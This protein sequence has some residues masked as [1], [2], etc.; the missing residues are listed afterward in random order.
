[1]LNCLSSKAVGDDDRQEREVSNGAEKS[2]LTGAFSSRLVRTWW[3]RGRRRRR[4]RELVA[5]PRLLADMGRTRET[6]LREASKPF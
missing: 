6:A 3:E 4:L 1:M 2:S 5:R